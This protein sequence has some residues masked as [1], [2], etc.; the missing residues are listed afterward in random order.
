M[1]PPHVEQKVVSVWGD[2]GRQWLADFPRLLDRAME[3]WR[4]TEI[5]PAPDLS[6]NFVAFAQQNGKPVV[7]KMG[8]KNPELDREAEVLKAFGAAGA[9]TAID[10][11]PELSALLLERLMPGTTLWSEWTRERDEEHTRIAANLM[12]RL[13]RD[14]VPGYPRTEDWC[15][16][17][18]RHFAAY[19]EGGPVPRA[20][21]TQAQQLA[22]ELHAGT[23]THVLLHG[24]LHHGNILRSGETWKIID[25]KGANGDPAFE[26]G[27][28]LYNPIDRI[29]T[30]PD[31]A[32]MLRRRLEIIAEVTGIDR[33]RL[34]NWAFCTAVLSACWSAEDGESDQAVIRCA[35]ALLQDA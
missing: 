28:F 6:Y 29:D 3:K 14:P 2:E 9:A 5:E 33:E 1:I 19:P 32:R 17:F 15:L 21:V 10:Y 8:V 27:A 11:D 13:W 20:L 7:L 26:V 34:R 22:D 12:K 31:L 16:A 35:Q 30:V 24:D 18:D 4:L 23:T 25:P